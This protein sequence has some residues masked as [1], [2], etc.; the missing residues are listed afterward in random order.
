V[1]ES[2]RRLAREALSG[3]KLEAAK[4]LAAS[5]RAGSVAAGKVQLLA[6]LGDPVARF[7]L[8][9]GDVEEL[10]AIPFLRE[11]PEANVPV[12]APW[13]GVLAAVAGAAAAR[14][15]LPRFEE[16]HPDDARV[17]ALL[18]VI[19]GAIER[20]EL[21]TDLV[22]ARDA[23]RACDAGDV[24]CDPGCCWSED[25]ASVAATLVVA[26]RVA[27]LSGEPFVENHFT[28]DL[29]A[30]VEYAGGA[31]LALP[32][33]RE[34]LVNWLRLTLGD[35][36]ERRGEARTVTFASSSWESPLTSDEGIAVSGHGQSFLRWL[37]SPFIGSSG[38]H[39]AVRAFVRNGHAQ[40]LS[41]L[42]RTREELSVAGRLIPRGSPVAVVSVAAR[43]RA[44]S[45]QEDIVSVTVET[46]GRRVE[47][48]ADALEL[49]QRGRQSGGGP[50]Q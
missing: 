39:A 26:E 38:G 30:A 24:T 35:S 50:L 22:S 18:D 37:L 19:D 45:T 20:P 4:A 49:D 31:E 32:A 44:G 34:A 12:A 28:A 41:V 10:D 48:R 23:A 1:D 40:P 17:R 42:A 7:A 15:L 9:V 21:I 16:M 5:L 2:D 27:L 33:A 8:G 25:T 46:R 43:R 3:G 6:G 29:V 11:D 36:G 14:A 47:T 13:S